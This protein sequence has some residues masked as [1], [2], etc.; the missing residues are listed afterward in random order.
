MR[1]RLVKTHHKK[2]YYAKRRF[3]IGAFLL[4]GISFAVIMPTYFSLNNAELQNLHAEEK[5][6]EPTLSTIDNEQI[7]EDNPS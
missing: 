4:L 2:N 5:Q 7:S 1:D 3:F 6:E